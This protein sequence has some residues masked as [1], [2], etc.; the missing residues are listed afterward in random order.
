MASSWEKV[1]GAEWLSVM[2]VQTGDAL[3]GSQS[4]FSLPNPSRYFAAMIV[5]FSLAAVAMFGEKPAKFAAAFG[6]LA[7]LGMLLAP[8]KAGGKP[9]IMSFLDYV[10]GLMVNPPTNLDSQG[11]VVPGDIIN[12]KSKTPGLTNP[13]NPGYRVA[14]GGNQYIES[15]P[16]YNAPR[17][18]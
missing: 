10:T 18:A 13:S 15:P 7:A 5:Y 11:N 1:L 17:P 16:A 6:G 8:S 12:P 14:P 9:V 2:V 3:A 4:G